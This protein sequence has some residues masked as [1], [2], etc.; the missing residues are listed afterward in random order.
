MERFTY[1]DLPEKI[2]FVLVTHNHHDHFCL[3]SLLR[4][5]HKVESLVV[6]RSFGLFYGDVSLRLL[7]KNC[8][9]KHVIE[10]DTMDSISVPDGEIVDIPFMGEH[11]DLPMARWHMW[12]EPGP[13]KC[14][15]LQ[16]QT[17]WTSGCI[18]I[19]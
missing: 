17:A 14:S 19:S 5:P 8:G 18:D 16:I 7:A 12:F 6:L 2:D 3:E 15:S 11:A 9:F 4:I 10:L 13:N 1:R